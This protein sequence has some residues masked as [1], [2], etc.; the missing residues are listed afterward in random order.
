MIQLTLPDALRNWSRDRLEMFHTVSVKFFCDR[1]PHS[2]AL[3]QR[4]KCPLTLIH[5]GADIAYPIEYAQE[6]HDRIQ[7]AGLDVRLL[8]VKDAPHFGSVTHS[9]EY[10]N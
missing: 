2:P 10:V 1:Q 9:A 3:L 4:I 5:C 7:G 6:L 8:A